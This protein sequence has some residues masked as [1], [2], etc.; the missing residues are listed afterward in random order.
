MGNTDFILGQDVE[1]FESEFAD[2][3][4]VDFA[5]GVASGTDALMLMLKGCGVEPGDEVIFAVPDDPKTP[6]P[7]QTLAEIGYGE[8]LVPYDITGNGLLDI[9]AGYC[10]LENMGDGSFEPHQIVADKG[11]YPARLA[12]VDVNGNGRPDVVLGEEVRDWTNK[13]A[14]FANLAWC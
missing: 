9:V 4:G 5:V 3:V 12:V 11:F 10:W 7:K 1:R 6:W 8:E 13:V 14:L 2:F